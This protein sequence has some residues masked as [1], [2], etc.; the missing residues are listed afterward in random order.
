PFGNIPANVFADAIDFATINGADILSNSWGYGTSDPNYQPVIVSAI[1]TAINNGKLV[2]FAAGNTANQINGNN[3]YITFPGSGNI[4]NLITVGASDRNNN[5]A[6]YSPDGIGLE[7]S[8]PSHTAYNTQ[9]TGESYNI[10]T[11]DIPGSNYGYNSWRDY[12]GGL[13]TNGEI[14][15]NYGTNYADYTGRMGGTSAAT[16]EVAGVA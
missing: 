16:P 13:P 7:I 5:Q 9:I 1:N 8:A 15:P 6:N 11:I 10:W 4:E 14:L 12:A 2:L 3:G